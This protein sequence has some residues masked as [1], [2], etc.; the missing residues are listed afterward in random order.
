MIWDYFYGSFVAAEL[1]PS[2]GFSFLHIKPDFTL[3][4]P[5][6]PWL[7]FRLYLAFLGE[8]LYVLLTRKEQWVSPQLI[9]VIL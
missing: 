3:K 5:V 9:E 8:N 4:Y 7:G 6:L 2:D 1:K